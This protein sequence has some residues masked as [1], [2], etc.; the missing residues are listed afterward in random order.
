[1]SAA[2]VAGV[3]AL[4]RTAD[5]GTTASLLKGMLLDSV[6]FPDG[7]DAG[8]INAA[9]AVGETGTGTGGPGT[10]VGWE[11]CDEDHDGEANAQ[12]LCPGVPGHAGDGCP[13]TDGDTVHDGKDNC[14]LA[15]NPGQRDMDGDGL[16]DDCDPDADGDTLA[17]ADDRCP[18]IAA[19]TLDGCPADD[20]AG[21]DG[22]DVPEVVPTPPTFTP[23]PT[24]TPVPPTDHQTIFTAFSAKVTPAHCKA[25]PRCKKAAKLTIKVSKTTKVSLKVERRSG[26]KWKRY[27]SKTL[28]VTAAGKKLT[29]RGKGGRTLA[30]GSYRVIAS[31]SGGQNRTTTFRVV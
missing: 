22:P 18:R 25:G 11:S 29:F 13:D 7:L 19:R 12:D 3:A 2:V 9:K 4:A 21:P 6:D 30:K 28:T 15:A 5:P 26:K 17:E 24:P 27:T 20:P 14:E 10:T 31:I 1:M 8:R 16:G 23:T